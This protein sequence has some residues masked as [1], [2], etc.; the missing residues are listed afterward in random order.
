M[1][2]AAPTDTCA[3]FLAEWISDYIKPHPRLAVTLRVGDRNA[4][5]ASRGIGYC[6]EVW[7][8][9][10]FVDDQP[11]VD[12]VTPFSCSIVAPDLRAGRLVRLLAQYEGEAVPISAVMP[13][14]RFVTA[15]VR[16]M[17]DYLAQ[18]FAESSVK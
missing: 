4:R 1:H 6:S 14:G 2:I 5:S 9:E 16:A 18:R 8:A 17:V 13:S 11:R 15:R 7:G 12:A 3:Q 10:R